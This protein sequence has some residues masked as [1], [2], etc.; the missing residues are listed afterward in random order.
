MDKIRL[1]LSGSPDFLRQYNWRKGF[2]GGK[3]S[4]SF[5]AAKELSL[6]LVSMRAYALSVEGDA[7]LTVHDVEMEGMRHHTISWTDAA[8]HRGTGTAT[9]TMV[10]PDSP[11]EPYTYTLTVGDFSVVDHSDRS[12]DADSLDPVDVRGA[13]AMMSHEAFYLAL[14]NVLPLDV[15]IGA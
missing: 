8:K 1:S 6:F 14:S 13:L 12:G 2:H 15:T 4:I 11:A 5:P 3:M 10:N 9:V 7:T